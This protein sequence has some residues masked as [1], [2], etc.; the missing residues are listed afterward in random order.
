[1]KHMQVDSSRVELKQQ[2]FLGC[3]AG[4]AVHGL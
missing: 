3:A 1:M 2:R 4:L